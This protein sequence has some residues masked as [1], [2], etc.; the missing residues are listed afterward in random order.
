[1]QYGQ[2]QHFNNTKSDYEGLLT[3]KRGK[4]NCKE[5]TGGKN[6]KIITRFS[7]RDLNNIFL[8]NVRDVTDSKEKSN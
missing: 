4:H 6:C 8:I 1:M 5:E 2:Q 7:L 3:V